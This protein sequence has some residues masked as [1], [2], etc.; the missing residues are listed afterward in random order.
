MGAHAKAAAIG[1]LLIGVLATA[2]CAQAG[3]PVGPRTSAPRHTTGSAVEATPTP[4]AIETAIKHEV[5]RAIPSY[6]VAKA[7]VVS[8]VRDS[9]GRWWV[10]GIFWRSTDQ[11]D[12]WLTVFMVKTGDQRVVIDAGMDIDAAYDDRIP[13]DVRSRL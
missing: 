5:P 2:S 9:R 8:V 1:A 7:K 11:P 12:G 6:R 13:A 10:R 4:A 3:A